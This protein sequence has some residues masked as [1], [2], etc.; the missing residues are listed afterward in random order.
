MF[1]SNS[2]TDSVCVWERHPERYPR[3]SGDEKQSLLNTP[4]LWSSRVSGRA[5][6]EPHFHHHET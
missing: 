1:H 2:P 4:L 5:W 6:K 3:A